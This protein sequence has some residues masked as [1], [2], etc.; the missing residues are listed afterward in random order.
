[1][2][3]RLLSKCP[4]V[5]SEGLN[6]S[7]P[8]LIAARNSQGAGPDG[9]RLAAQN[10][11]VLAE[12][13]YEDDIVDIRDLVPSL[14]D[15]IRLLD[16]TTDRVSLGPSQWRFV[17]WR[18]PDR[19][20]ILLLAQGSG[21]KTD[22]RDLQV[23]GERLRDLVVNLH[24]VALWSHNADRLSRD[25]VNR[26]RLV[27]AVDANREAGFPCEVGYAN[28]GTLLQHESWDI[29]MYFEARQARMQAEATL[30][31]TRDAQRLR[32]DERMTDGRF[33]ISIPNA[34]PPGLG[35]N[36]YRDA[37]GLRGQGF[38]YLD[39]PEFR[40]SAGEVSEPL[41]VCRDDEGEVAD[42]VANV[43]WAL[44]EFAAGRP[45]LS[46]ARTL[47]ARG[48]STT[49]L[50]WRHTRG[51]TFRSVFG[52]PDGAVARR[53]LGSIYRAIDFYETGVL[54]TAIGGR[55]FSIAN[56]LPLG[57]WV[58]PEDAARI[59]TRVKHRTYTP[60]TSPPAP[61]PLNGLEVTLNGAPYRLK[62]E[63]RVCTCGV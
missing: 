44:A 37:K 4:R 12:A 6:P 40:P 39:T 17:E 19:M 43:R 33:R 36:H 58:S 16:T 25:E 23:F 50:G 55:P 57:G 53:M 24:P 9:R 60:R 15:L 34:L 38:A 5:V 26:L 61:L 30:R 28:K 27:R 21:T 47:A 62:G 10:A 11:R 41:H 56:C 35:R 29:S 14:E 46:I 13:L 51:A 22:D 7:R 48:Y 63:R 49:G 20:L 3:K 42:Q 52:E 8:F 32:T 2:H 59:R 18:S 45:T 1:M 54:H 31:R